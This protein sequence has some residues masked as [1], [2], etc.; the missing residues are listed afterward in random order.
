[1][2]GENLPIVGKLLGH[3]CHRTTAGY[4][5]LTDRHVIETAERVGG[6]SSA[7]M[8]LNASHTKQ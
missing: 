8:N 5:H 1:M 3:Q 4:A 2:L 7:M 6:I